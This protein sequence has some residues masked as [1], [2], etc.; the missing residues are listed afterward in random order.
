MTI[1]RAVR[2]LDMPQKAPHELRQLASKAWVQQHGAEWVH[3][4]VGKRGE[5][6]DAAEFV[7][8]LL[9][10][11]MGPDGPRLG[12]LIA[13]ATRRPRGV[14][15]NAVA[16]LIYDA[17]RKHWYAATVEGGRWWVHDARSTMCDAAKLPVA[18]R[19]A[20]VRP[21]KGGETRLTATTCSCGR[22]T[23]EHGDDKWSVR[24]GACRKTFIGACANVDAAARELFKPPA[25]WHCD[26]CMRRHRGPN[27]EA[28]QRY[29]RATRP[30]S[31]ATA[32]TERA[33]PPAY[34]SATPRAQPDCSPRRR[35]ATPPAPPV[36]D[37]AVPA[38]RSL[39]PR[40]PAWSPR[41]GKAATGIRN[42]GNT[43]FLSAALQLLAHTPPLAA[44]AAR[45]AERVATA[46]SSAAAP[47]KGSSRGQ[48]LRDA[49]AVALANMS[50]SAVPFAPY[51]LA[52]ALEVYGFERGAQ[53]DAAEVLE[54]LL[55][56]LIADEECHVA[57][58]ELKQTIVVTRRE[59]RAAVKRRLS[60][61]RHASPVDERAVDE[62]VAL[63]KEVRGASPRF[64]ERDGDAVLATQTLHTRPLFAALPGKPV[65]LSA[66]IAKALGGVVGDFGVA[67][68]PGKES[69]VSQP[70]VTVQARFEYE[71]LV[72]PEALVIRL[73]RESFVDG[74]AS[75]VRTRV[76]LEQRIDLAALL[77]P[78]AKQAGTQY[79]LAAVIAHRGESLRAGHYAA[80]VAGAP[81]GAA[82]Q[83]I[84]D[85]QV[86]PSSIDAFN[87]DAAWDAYVVTY[88]RCSPQ[89][90]RAQ[91]VA[92]TGATFGRTAA[93]SVT[94]RSVGPGRGPPAAPVTRPASGGSAT[95][96]AQTARVPVSRV[97]PA[98]VEAPAVIRHVDL[99][100][101][102]DLFRC[103]QVPCPNL[104]ALKGNA[105]SNVVL[106]PAMSLPAANVVERYRQTHQRTLAPLRWRMGKTI[107]VRR[108]HLAAL[109]TVQKALR[110]ARFAAMPF[111][112]AVVTT[113]RERA[114]ERS[115]RAATLTRELA[116]FAGA[117]ADLA[118]YSN[119][120]IGFRMGEAP[121]FTD[122]MRAA[123]LVA[124]EE[125]V[126][127]QP[128]ATVEE[129]V[130]AV[131][132]APDVA[133]RVALALTWCCA[134]RVGDV[135]KLQRRDVQ[136]DPQF[137]TNG[138]MLITFARGKGA[139]L[140]QPYTVPTLCLEEWRP[141]VLQY[142][143]STQPNAWVFPG[144]TQTFG[145]LVNLALRTANPN[146]SV[147]AIRRGALQAM[148]ADGAP[149]AVLVIF[150]GHKSADTLHR[151]LNWGAK[152]AARSSSGFEA[153]ASLARRQRPPAP[154][155]A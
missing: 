14:S 31:S 6:A 60:A 79:E 135:L 72:F 39:N 35:D 42:V 111:A 97:A 18:A 154:R 140:G 20:W 77:P 89:A 7:P 80:L 108:R 113:F 148:A 59:L 92:T 73:G 109:H 143:N 83:W 62:L 146:Y 2:A 56:E 16:A 58:V 133:V 86:R 104:A 32:P 84:D 13:I 145:V 68:A 102:G 48:L 23:A 134:G 33:P 40:A 90:T 17:G 105:L 78:E 100:E 44:A 118:L 130:D 138:A 46:S 74:V 43:C 155:L 66:L 64:E 28:R 115:W 25:A 24:C 57:S 152:S 70:P 114:Q 99:K 50:P 110:H 29:A 124:N 153:A 76:R 136:L 45:Q 121:F 122:A 61:A 144:G 30:A 41:L 137:L 54:W 37:I 96:A 19:Y 49:L 141:M 123:Q 151:Y 94:G 150:S 125:M 82:M 21:A 15:A 93:T 107:A 117:M 5:R 69:P 139:L 51:G 52:A 38:P 67:V 71:P 4:V 103:S 129:M 101:C 127:S 12:D 88:V 132:L 9:D 26:G 91:P 8:R 34:E 63:G 27:G 3:S 120:P 106:A 55:A 22:T 116:N 98:D 75:K 53:H 147:R 142:L 1:G 36:P 112:E 65:A 85:A 126:G 119:S 11:R 131:N 128:A 81:G 87:D 95:S 10:E 47:P 149:D